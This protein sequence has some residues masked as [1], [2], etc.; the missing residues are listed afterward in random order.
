M[1]GYKLFGGT[2]KLIGTWLLFKKCGRNGRYSLIPFVNHYQLGV[3]AD[4]EKDGR[5]LM[6]FGSASDIISLLAIIFEDGTTVN[7]ILDILL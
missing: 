2:L 1:L 7:S 3:C 4:R 6:I 5:M